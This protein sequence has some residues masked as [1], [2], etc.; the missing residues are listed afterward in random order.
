MTTMTRREL[1]D[2]IWSKPM[3]DAARQVGLSDVGLKKVCIRHRVPVPPQGYWNRIK[4]GHKPR[5]TTFRE[6]DDPELNC[7]QILGAVH[8]PSV[9]IKKVLFEA[10]AR[11]E[12]PERKI[13][14][15]DA[16]PTVPAAMRLA[17]ALRKAKKD[18]K[19]LVTAEGPKL[20]SVY[21]SP[22]NIGRAVSIVEA[23][24]VAAAD[25]GFGVA[26]GEKC[27][28][29]T[30]EGESVALKLR[31]A[32]KRTDH[33]E[34]QEEQDREERRK[35]AAQ[36]G[37]WG[38]HS[39]LYQ[40][41]P[42]W[43]YR[44]LGQLILEVENGAYMGVRARWSDTAKRK[45]ETM[46]NDVLVG[47]SAFA[48]ALKQ[49]KA[50]QERRERQWALERQRA[51]KERELAALEKARLGF[52]EPRLAAFDEMARLQ[53]FLGQLEDAAQWTESPAR[54]QDFRQWAAARVEKL[55]HFCSAE[56]LAEALATSPLFGPKP[57]SPDYW[58][59]W[60]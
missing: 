48:A 3:R 5:V 60:D 39:R 40:P 30:V 56:G 15:S 45:I 11:E 51:E 57:R 35:R 31:E 27:L 49:R 55:R 37:N 24:L 2:L 47:L 22:D 23:L 58:P 18:E 38:L 20:F 43:D 6:V 32:T 9:E 44:M 14:V 4:A 1:Y 46:L 26:A 10:K 19:G 29:L 33:V 50:E 53:R 36:S 13:E 25:R 7:V 21:V 42:R 41:K 34:T 59:R 54:L 52:L 17:A 28:L 16:P 8:G 12:A